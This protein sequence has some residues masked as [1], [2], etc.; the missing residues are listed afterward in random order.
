MQ[1]VDQCEITIMYIRNIM[2]HRSWGVAL[3]NMKMQLYYM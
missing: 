2:Y 3:D 1:N